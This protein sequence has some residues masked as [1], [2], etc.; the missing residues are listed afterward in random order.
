MTAAKP[1]PDAP[2]KALSVH[3]SADDRRKLKL[4]ADALDTSESG[5]ARILIQQGL[6]RGRA[7]EAAKAALDAV[8]EAEEKAAQ[9]QS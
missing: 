7:G 3:L 8:D 1:E 5:M 6:R 9:S 2:K 4:R